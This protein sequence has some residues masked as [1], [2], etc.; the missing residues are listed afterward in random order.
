ISVS[1]KISMPILPELSDVFVASFCRF[2]GFQ[3]FLSAQCTD[4]ETITPG[5][6]RSAHTYK[7]LCPLLKADTDAGA[8][9]FA[10]GVLLAG[11]VGGQQVD[12]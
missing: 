4:I 1:L 9:A 3:R 12:V 5:V 10:V 8:A 7:S 2:T 11:V 6:A